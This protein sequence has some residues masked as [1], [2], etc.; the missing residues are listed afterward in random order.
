MTDIQRYT[1][2]GYG[3]QQ[4][5]LMPTPD[6]SWVT[7]AD[8]VEA[9]QRAYEDGRKYQDAAVKQAEQR[10][11]EQGE[12]AARVG[13]AI[14]LNLI[15]VGEMRPSPNGIYE[16]IYAQGQRDALAAAVARVEALCGPH[17][18]V[19]DGVIAAIKG[20]QA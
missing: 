18:E 15:L 13:M 14:D 1:A 9:L 2:D 16:R 4:G 6:G 7:Y 20:E 3:A 12:I 17:E 8:H 10:G 19:P 11:R 5:E